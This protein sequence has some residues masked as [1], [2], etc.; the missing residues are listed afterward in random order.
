MSDLEKSIAEWREQ[1]LAAGIKSPAPLDELELH[2]R[3]E[4]E[5]QTKLGLSAEPAFHAAVQKIGTP[6]IIRQEY[7]KLCLVDSQKLVRFR[8]CAIFISLLLAV[9]LTTPEVAIQLLTFVFLVSAYEMG[10]WNLRCLE[11]KTGSLSQKIGMGMTFMALLVATIIRLAGVP[12]IA[13]MSKTTHQNGHAIVDDW[14]QP[15]WYLFALLG[16]FVIGVV[17]AIWP[18]RKKSAWVTR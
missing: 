9:F 18:K 2:L 17:L 16:L 13:R 5:W 10:I 14:W 11:D 8:P 3:E 7:Q 15:Q 1:M 4:M 6:K 12:F